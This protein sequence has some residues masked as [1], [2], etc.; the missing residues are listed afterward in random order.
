MQIIAF[1]PGIKGSCT[2][3]QAAKAPDSD[4]AMNLDSGGSSGLWLRGTYLRTPG[5]L[6]SNA[7]LLQE[8]R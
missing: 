2:D 1:E 8:K 7:L 6:I 5:R 3:A 4:Q